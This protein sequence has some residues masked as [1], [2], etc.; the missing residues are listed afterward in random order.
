MSD[1]SVCHIFQLVG[2]ILVIMPMTV[3]ISL[4]PNLKPLSE[5]IINNCGCPIQGIVLLSSLVSNVITLSFYPLL[6]DLTFEQV[7]PTYGFLGCC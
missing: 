1:L 3:Q 6:R 4:V 5:E 7:G 2:T